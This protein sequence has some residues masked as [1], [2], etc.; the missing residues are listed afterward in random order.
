M[1]SYNVVTSLVPSNWSI[2]RQKV[3]TNTYHN[4]GNYQDKVVSLLSLLGVSMDN[5][6]KCI[7]C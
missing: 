5:V 1:K 2:K 4:N 6:T 7:K 3:V